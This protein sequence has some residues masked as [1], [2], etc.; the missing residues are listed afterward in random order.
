[1]C[2]VLI[3]AA[4]DT[5]IRGVD[6]WSG[7]QGALVQSSGIHINKTAHSHLLYNSLV[8]INSLQS[9]DSGTYTFS[10]VITDATFSHY[11]L[12]SSQTTASVSITVGKF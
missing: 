7:P 6:Q 10:V 9:S 12:N 11:V 2:A 1:M 8:G 5:D 3:N 4:V